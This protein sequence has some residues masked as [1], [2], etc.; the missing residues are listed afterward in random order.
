M[1]AVPVQPEW[2]ASSVGYLRG[3][4]GLYECPVYSTSFRGPTYIFIATLKTTVPSTK[5]I[6]SGCALIMQLDT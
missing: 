1:K 4:P 3:D 2:E 6:L 5:W